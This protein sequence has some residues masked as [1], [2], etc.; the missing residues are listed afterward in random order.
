MF[1]KMV[2]EGIKFALFCKSGLQRV[3]K[4]AN[5]MPNGAILKEECKKSYF[6]IFLMIQFS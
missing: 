3:Q 6:D 4:S 5:F 1:F 2:P